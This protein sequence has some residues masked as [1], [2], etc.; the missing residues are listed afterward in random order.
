[1]SLA[2]RLRHVRF[3]SELSKT[4]PARSSRMCPSVV[5]TK[6]ASMQDGYCSEWSTAC[7]RPALALAHPGQ[8]SVYPNCSKSV[9]RDGARRTCRKSGTDGG[10][11][12]ATGLAPPP[13]VPRHQQQQCRSR[14][15]EATTLKGVAGAAVRRCCLRL[16]HRR[17]NRHHMKNGV[18]TRR[19]K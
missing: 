8:L 5:V 13:P 14:V 19:P 1:M 17:L 9:R 3:P 15:S 2:R 12:I 16:R 11:G 4:L 7:L 6:I 18:W 10:K